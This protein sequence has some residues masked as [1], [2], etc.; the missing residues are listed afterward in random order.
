MAKGKR[1]SNSTVDELF[2]IR[3]CFN[4]KLLA[5]LG[6]KRLPD[7]GYGPTKVGNVMVMIRPKFYGLSFSTRAHRTVAECPKCKRWVCAGHL[8]QHW[9]ACRD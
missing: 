8:G 5:Q 9:E 3:S 6:F 2:G 4:H 7:A 1:Y